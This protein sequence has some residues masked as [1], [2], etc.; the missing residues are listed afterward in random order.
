M[1]RTDKQLID[2]YYH[3][4]RVGQTADF[5][6]ALSAH[7]WHGVAKHSPLLKF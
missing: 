6:Q 4:P 1:G 3:L 5:S 2:N 7:G